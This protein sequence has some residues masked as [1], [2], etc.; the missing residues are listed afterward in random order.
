MSQKRFS[1]EERL[2]IGIAALSGPASVAS[3]AR[4]A[5][6]HPISITTWMEKVLKD[7]PSFSTE[8]YIGC[9]GTPGRGRIRAARDMWKRMQSL[10]ASERPLPEWHAGLENGTRIRNSLLADGISNREEVLA[11]LTAIP[12]RPCPNIGSQAIDAIRA[13]FGLPSLE[14]MRAQEGEVRLRRR[15]EAATALLEANGYTVLRHGPPP[16]D[17]EKQS[18]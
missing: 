9:L 6:C 10:P 2:R 15:I 12:L 3:L 18:L 16:L 17:T 5:G 8:S 7:H 14:P 11:W 13:R 4:I 1:H